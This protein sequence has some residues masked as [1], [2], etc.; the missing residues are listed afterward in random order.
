MFIVN[1]DG[2]KPIK[3]WQ[4]SI[5]SIEEECLEQAKH[6]AQ[7]PFIYQWVSLMPDT[8]SGYG[9]PIGG[10]IACD[11]VVIPNAVGVDIGC[12][13]MAVKTNITAGEIKHKIK[14]ICDEINKRVPTGFNRHNK[15]LESLEI[16]NWKSE[17]EWQCSLYPCS[18]QELFPNKKDVEDVMCKIGT[19]G[20]GNHFIELQEDSEGYVW[21]MLHSGSRNLGKKIGDYFNKIA[22]DMNERYWSRV[23]KEWNLAFLDAESEYGKE[24]LEWMDLAIK[25]ALLNRRQIM[26]LITDIF[27]SEFEHVIF[28]NTINCIHNYAAL[29]DHMGKA[30]Y[31]HRKG[32]INAEAGKIGI[33]PGSMGSYSYIVRGKGDVQSFKSASHGA[34]RAMSRRAAAAKYSVEDVVKDQLNNNFVISTNNMED[35]AEESRFAYKDVTQVVQQESTLVDIV[36]TLKTLGVVKG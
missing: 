34:G 17:F 26:Y 16:E 29:E 9:M 20:G 6:L 1:A 36:E 8:H 19:L 14:N 15:P 24:Y 32:A 33:I 25:Y 18:A 12:G 5:N 23:P 7:L 22:Q 3:I 28:E 27:Y 21:I 10:V 2:M 30:V 4:E 13:M 31:V 11:G 35:I